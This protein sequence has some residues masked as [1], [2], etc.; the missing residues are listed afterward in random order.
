[1]TLYY[2][3]LRSW[4]HNRISL[5]MRAARVA[6]A[7]RKGSIVS[8][9][10]QLLRVITPGILWF[11]LRVYKPL[12]AHRESAPNFQKCKK[13]ET[14]QKNNQQTNE[15]KCSN[16]LSRLLRFAHGLVANVPSPFASPRLAATPFARLRFAP[17]SGV[18]PKT[19]IQ[20]SDRRKYRKWVIRLEV[21]PAL[22]NRWP[23]PFSRTFSSGSYRK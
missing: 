5:D 12:T 21:I 3:F 16:A 1:M 14:I 8:P 4:Y 15:A 23:N 11:N 20:K 18:Q 17:P 6:T 22:T 2:F 13:L 7:N 10:F 19:K 9:P